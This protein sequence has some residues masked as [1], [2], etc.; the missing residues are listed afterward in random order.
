MKKR[1]LLSVA[2]KEG[3]PEFAKGLVERGFEI[4]SS[5]GTATVLEG[6][7]IPVK[8]VSEI[9]G[10]P[11]ILGGRVKTLHPMIH[12]GILA[13]RHLEDDV[14]ELER[15]GIVPVDV[16]AVNFYPFEKTLAAGRPIE[17]VLENIDIG[18]PSMLRAS[19]KNFKDVLSVT[20]PK[21]YAVILSKLGEGIGVDLETRL[22][23]AAKAFAASSRY[24]NA[25]AAFLARLAADGDTLALEDNASRF[26]E[27]LALRFTKV[28]D[29]RYGENPHQAA[30]FYRDSAL[31]VAGATKLH[32]KELSYNNILDLDAA[33]RLVREL[34]RSGA[35]AVVIKHTNPAGAALGASLVDAYVNARATDPVS[36]FGGIVALNRPVDG[37][38]AEELAS[39]FLE[40][41][42]SPSFEPEALEILTKKK[43]LRLMTVPKTEIDADPLPW[44]GRN[45]CRVLG[46]VLVQD[47]DVDGAEEAFE[48]VT[49]RVPTDSQERTLRLAWIAAKHV[50]SNAIVLAKGDAL[51]G[52]GAGQM[53]RVDSC[54]IAVEKAQS[55]VDGSVAA[56]DAFFPFRD[57]VDALADAGVVAVVQPGGSVRDDE[58]I[59]AA[60]ERGVAMALTRKRHFRH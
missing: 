44:D 35:A 19:A 39:T 38:T 24:E 8:R 9:T 45:L 22:Y 11:E 7:N 12:G 36:A 41:I 27:E 55:P 51:L 26:P 21:D 47:W 15:Q 14:S 37:A 60:N 2:D 50:K 5:G 10:F 23:L 40:A 34:P 6:A 25:I 33:W 20:D 32:G 53:S 13:R 18:G 17:E 29:L 31:A 56:S 30:A 48:V 4:V 3:L 57:G 28:Q 54:R 59:A 49:E 42:I 1:A 52:V 43:N 58:V 16:V 46:G